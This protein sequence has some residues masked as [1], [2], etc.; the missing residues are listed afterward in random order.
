M[1]QI[2]ELKKKIE[3]LKYNHKEELETLRDDHARKIKEEIDRVKYQFED[4]IRQMQFDFEGKLERLTSEKDRIIQDLKNQIAD[5]KKRFES[6][7][8]DWHARIKEME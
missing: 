7:N 1:N 5:Y 8:E 6:G 4:K 3:D 2:D